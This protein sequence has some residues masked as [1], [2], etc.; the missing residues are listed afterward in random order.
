MGT[1]KKIRR[2]MLHH[3][4]LLV[5]IIE[6]VVGTDEHLA[7]METERPHVEAL[8]GEVTVAIRREQIRGMIGIGSTIA[9]IAQPVDTILVAIVT[10]D[11]IGGRM[12]PACGLRV[13]LFH[14]ASVATVE[15][16]GTGSVG[17]DGKI[18]GTLPL[19]SVDDIAYTWQTGEKPASLVPHKEPVVLRTQIKIVAH[20]GNLRQGRLSRELTGQPYGTHLAALGKI[21]VDS[22]A[23]DKTNSTIRETDGLPDGIAQSNGGEPP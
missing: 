20:S 13:K 9:G 18:I 16:V 15:K 19:H 21:I 8:S 2:E 1:P 17:S 4:T 14:D 12:V 3:A 7:A 5:D 6:P 11:G 22:L 10:V 23:C